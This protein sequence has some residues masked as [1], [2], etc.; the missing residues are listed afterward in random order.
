MSKAQALQQAARGKRRKPLGKRFNLPEPKAR[1]SLLRPG[2]MASRVAHPEVNTT[3][4][5]RAG[6][7]FRT[8][9][10]DGGNEVH[11]YENGERV[12]VRKGPKSDGTSPQK[13]TRTPASD[14]SGG[15]EAPE[16]LNAKMLAKA[17]ERALRRKRRGRPL[18][19]GS[20]D[21]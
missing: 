9:K 20:S 11:V 17:R 13:T 7:K 5:R 16:N 21:G 4:N 6:Q 14:G 2:S 12:F 18:G 19:G 15:A 10:T 8:E 3:G 1:V